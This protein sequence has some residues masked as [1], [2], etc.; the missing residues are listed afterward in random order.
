MTTLIVGALPNTPWQTLEPVLV[1]LGWQADPKNPPE[2]WLQQPASQQ[3][4]VVLFAHPTVALAQALRSGSTPENA[5]NQWLEHSQQA[6]NT[7]RQQRK[8]T[9][10][11][12][13]EQALSNPNALIRTVQQRLNVTLDPAIAEHSLQNTAQQTDTADFTAHYTEYLLAHYLFST[14]STA[15]NLLNVLEAHSIPL[16]ETALTDAANGLPV[17]TLFTAWQQQQEQ[18]A[19]QHATHQAEQTEWA[20]QKQEQ[21]QLIAKVQKQNTDLH[22]ENALLLEQL[23]SVQEKLEEKWIEAQTTQETLRNAQNELKT[24]QTEL[25]DLQAKLQSEQ[26]ATKQAHQATQKAEKALKQAQQTLESTQKDLT[27]AQQTLASTQEDLKKAKQAQKNAEQTSKKQQYELQKENDLILNQLFHVQEELERHFLKLKSTEKTLADNKAKLKAS[28]AELQQNQTETDRLRHAVGLARHNAQKHLQK[29]QEKQPGL[30]TR[31]GIKK[32]QEPTWA[33]HLNTLQQTNAVA[34][35]WY[36]NTYPDVAISGLSATEHYLKFGA[37][38]NRN[39]SPEF[40]TA[41][42]LKEYPDVAESGL[43]PLVHY[44]KFGQAEGRKAKP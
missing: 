22:S 31:L 43:N 34:E 4:Q 26:Q 2:H 15:Q 42:Y 41:W 9:V 21:D 29:Q 40:D 16:T 10:L 37:A 17:D 18:L 27:A 23:H 13:L 35:D 14:S 39:P 30:L 1:T 38:E 25:A 12:N 44:I 20:T 7:V 5:L 8:N 6:L 33:K 3:Q 24:A 28:Q 19:Q 11:V 32:K 36:L